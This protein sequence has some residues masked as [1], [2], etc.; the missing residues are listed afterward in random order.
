MSGLRVTLLEGDGIGPAA[1]REAARLLELLAARYGFGCEITRAEFGLAAYRKT[2][3]ALPPGTVAAIKASDAAFF[4]AVDSKGVEGPTPVGLLRR[5][6]GLYADIRPIRSYGGRALRPGLDLVVVRETTQGFLSDR[7]LYAGSGEWM[8]DADTAFSL[9]VVSY[10]ASQ[11]I[12]QFAFSYARAHGRKKVTAVHK[13]SI[14]KLSCGTFLRACRDTAAAY[15]E[16]SYEEEAA[17]ATANGLVAH[18]ERYD[19]VLTTNLFGDILSD[20]ASALA[21]DAV[22]SVN[23]GAG[24]RI[25]SPVS[26][27][28]AYRRLEEDSYDPLPTL[29][30]LRAL[31]EDLGQGQAACALG[32]CSAGIALSGGARTSQVWAQVRAALEGA[33]GGE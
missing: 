15:P 30:C 6:L 19:I 10:A 16:I 20:E 4:A 11:R 13:A 21:G 18:P 29:L 25:Y 9:R 1:A 31:L 3:C 24:A 23:L 27:D 2:G 8:S 33:H 32:R 14:F 26:H 28:P 7:N 5:Q 22:P 12:A 17:D